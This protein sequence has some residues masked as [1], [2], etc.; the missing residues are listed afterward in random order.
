M[1]SEYART[2][3]KTVL[4]SI[5]MISLKRKDSL[6]MSRLLYTKDMQPVGVTCNQHAV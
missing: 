2:E 1:V 6:R 5:R 3:W 4:V